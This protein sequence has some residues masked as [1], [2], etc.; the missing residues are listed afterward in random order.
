MAKSVAMKPITLSE[1]LSDA[2]SVKE[3]NLEHTSLR[4]A[5]IATSFRKA[6]LKLS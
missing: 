6:V 1:R 5:R 2:S 4:Y 3:P